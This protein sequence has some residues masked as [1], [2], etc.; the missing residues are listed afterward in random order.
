MTKPEKRFIRSAVGSV[1]LEGGKVSL[2]SIKTMLR[3]L[4]KEITIDEVV[5]KIIDRAINGG[6]R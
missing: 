3:L 6:V 4:R 1:E 5:D 2:S